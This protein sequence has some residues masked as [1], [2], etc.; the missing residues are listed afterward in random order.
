M[1]AKFEPETFRDAVVQDLKDFIAEN[2][3][4]AREPEALSKQLFALGDSFDLSQRYGELL[5]DILFVGGM[6]DGGG[7]FMEPDADLCPVSI[8]ATED[9]A[10]SIKKTTEAIALLLRRYR[11]AC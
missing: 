11:Y 8:F 3:E 4:A 1:K 5:L 6:L 10:E 7:A 2:G 9:K